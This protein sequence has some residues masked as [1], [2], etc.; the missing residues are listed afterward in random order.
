MREG[1]LSSVTDPRS[2][3]PLQL[4]CRFL[5]DPVLRSNRIVAKAQKDHIATS[6]VA[7]RTNRIPAHC[8]SLSVAWSKNTRYCTPYAN[9]SGQRGGRCHATARCYPLLAA[10]HLRWRPWRRPWRQERVPVRV[11]LVL[12]EA[13]DEVPKD[14]QI[15]QENHPALQVEF[16]EQRTMGF[17]LQL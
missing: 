17:V 12:S 15:V 13:I 6:A 5:A 16:E 14:V 2:K 10:A 1:H 7:P 9:K 4:A 3:T 8:H 11:K